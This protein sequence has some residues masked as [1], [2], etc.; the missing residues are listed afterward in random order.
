MRGIRSTI[1]LLDLARSLVFFAASAV[2]LGVACE[3]E[4]VFEKATEEFEAG[5]YREAI[6]VIKHHGRRG[7]EVSAD[8]LLLEGRSWL[9]LGNESEAED[10]FAQCFSLDSTLAPS[11]AM[12]LRAEV[13]RSFEEGLPAKGKRFMLQAISYDPTLEFGPLDKVAGE[14]LLARKEYENS[15]RYLSAYL[16]EYQDTTGAAEVI[17]SLAAAYEGKGEF[18][19]AIELY[20]RLQQRYPKSRLNTTASWRLDNLLYRTAERLRGGG[21]FEEA[22]RILEELAFSS[23]SPLVRERANFLLGDMAE[24][25]GDP[26]RAV[27]YYTEVVNLN[28]GSSGRMM[29]KAKERIE[30]LESKKARP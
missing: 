30:K 14:L 1:S 17:M 29:E 12:S 13:Q 27:H 20:R 26:R 10:A 28:L 2:I 22:E 21:E 9:R 6:F 3:R 18:E 15:V 8:L 19:E 25:R 11:I 4:S 23:D 16:E 7:G 5:R 24:E